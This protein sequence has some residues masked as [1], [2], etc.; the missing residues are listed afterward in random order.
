[1][2]LAK[3]VH[4]VTASTSHQ[5][6]QRIR[7]ALNDLQDVTTLTPMERGRTM[8]GK[9]GRTQPP[10]FLSNGMLYEDRKGRTRAIFDPEPK[11]KI[12]WNYKAGF[13]VCY[14][15]ASFIL[16]ATNITV[17]AIW[18]IGATGL[19][20]W[21]AWKLAKRSYKQVEQDALNRPQRHPILSSDQRIGDAERD[22][23]ITELGIHFAA[24]RLDAGEYDDRSTVAVNAKTA[25]DLDKCL[26]D[27]PALTRD[28]QRGMNR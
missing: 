10:T 6:E 15:I 23:M 21:F 18:P 2:A 3:V 26:T 14:F 8:S 11:S 7:E 22:K 27:L 9:S 12:R 4:G 16:S 19:C 20:I 13:L 28:E 5:P 1:M 25:G 24:G 17:P